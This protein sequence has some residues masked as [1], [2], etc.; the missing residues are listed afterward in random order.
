[1]LLSL[2]KALAT[3]PAVLF[4]PADPMYI[5]HPDSVVFFDSTSASMGK[6]VF[7]YTAEGWLQ[8]VKESDVSGT[9]SFTATADYSWKKDTL[10]T[11][12]TY[13]TSTDIYYVKCIFDANGFPIKEWCYDSSGLV[14]IDSYV[15]SASGKLA[16]QLI[17]NPNPNSTGGDSV[18]YEYDAA[19]HL[20]SSTQYGN[21][22]LWSYQGF[23]CDASGRLVRFSPFDC[24]TQCT[25]SGYYGLFYY[26][27]N[28]VRR[29]PVSARNAAMNPVSYAFTC[30]NQVIVTSN[31]PAVLIDAIKIFDISGALMFSCKA[32]NGHRENLPVFSRSN[33]LY[34]LAIDTNMGRVTFK[35]NK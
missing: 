30:G 6:E 34:L 5:A 25:P 13:T 21:G 22:E 14:E 33:Q 4:Y 19:D 31:R 8:R 15:Y 24:T 2:L 27:K 32:K 20:V 1:M 28:A 7:S 26:S 35:I 18:I 23:T 29:N 11:N 10:V 3:V 16:K 17:Q 9:F 12:F